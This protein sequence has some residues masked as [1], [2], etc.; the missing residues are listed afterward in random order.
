M[1][2]GEGHLAW[3]DIYSFPRILFNIIRQE[4]K[5]V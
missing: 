4:G 3:G 1:A 5:Y 2:Q